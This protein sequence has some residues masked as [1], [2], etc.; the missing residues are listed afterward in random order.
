MVV[1]YTVTTTE[2]AR[3]DKAR[4]V[5]A[6]LLQPQRILLWA[7]HRRIPPAWLKSVY[8]HAQNIVDVA[9]AASLVPRSPR[10]TV[11]QVFEVVM[12]RQYPLLPGTP[13]PLS[14]RAYLSSDIGA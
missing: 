5:V 11:A 9:I 12:T 7:S 6:A 14:V 3:Q 4:G 10:P 1:V 8:A 2:V 13:L